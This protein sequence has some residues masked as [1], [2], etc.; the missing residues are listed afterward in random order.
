MDS[1]A[2]SSSFIPST[3]TQSNKSRGPSSTA[4][5]TW[6][7]S[8]TARAG[9]DPKL[10]YCIHCTEDPIF[11]TK[12]TTNMR[13][14]LKLKHKIIVDRVLG[15]V[16]A[17]ALQQLQQLY[18]WAESLGQTEDVDTQIFQ[19]HLNQDIINE[20]LVS[21]IVVRNLSFRIVE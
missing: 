6:A 2:D 10:K 14:Y 12:V 3:T 21:L 11:S 13:L 18:L 4:L 17:Q 8:R 7:H 16:Q 15:P 20:A 5:T 1:E 19:K 9:E